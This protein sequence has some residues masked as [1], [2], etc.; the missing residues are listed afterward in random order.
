MKLIY[1][2]ILGFSI[3]IFSCTQKAPIDF[4]FVLQNDI[5]KIDSKNHSLTRLFIP[6]D[7]TINIFFTQQDLN[8]IYTDFVENGLDTFPSNY[9]PNCSVAINPA[10]YDRITIH[11]NG[12]DYKIIYNYIYKCKSEVDTRRIEKIKMFIDNL[13]LIIKNKKEY[14]ELKETNMIFM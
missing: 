6:R 3:F 9:E 13:R 5:D 8:R 14:Q 7:T 10:I 1:F 4:S 2:A 11:F 12:K